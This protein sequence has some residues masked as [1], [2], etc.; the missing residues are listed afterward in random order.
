MGDGLDRQKWLR[1]GIPFEQP[2]TRQAQTTTTTKT[3]TRGAAV[4]KST[5]PLGTTQ[6]ET[7]KKNQ[8]N[9]GGII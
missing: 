6:E 5:T 4:S 8:K 1:K 2:G 7:M 3:K 9:L